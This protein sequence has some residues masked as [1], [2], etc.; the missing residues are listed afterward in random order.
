VVNPNEEQQIVTSDNP[1]DQDGQPLRR[2][3]NDGVKSIFSTVILLLLAPLIALGLTMY[4]FQSYQ[5]DGPSMQETLHHNDRLVVWK[6]PRTWASITGN[7][8]IPS[9]GDIVILHEAG[10]EA[11]GVGGSGDKQLVKRVLGLPGDRIVIRDGVITVYNT[12]YPQGYRPDEELPYGKTA[13][14]TPTVNDIEVTL[15]EDELYVVG[16]NR[17]NSLD[18]RTFGPVSSDQIVGKLVLRLLPLNQLEKF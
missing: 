11:F 15:G 18:S 3:S 14:L 16:D 5:V 8:Y 12:E 10:L 7:S 13:D 1:V 9:R 2:Q 6:L 4:V 17:T